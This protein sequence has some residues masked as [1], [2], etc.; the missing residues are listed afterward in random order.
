M[1][2][3]SLMADKY[4]IEFATGRYQRVTIPQIRKLLKD[5]DKLELGVYKSGGDP[6]HSYMTAIMQITISSVNE[7]DRVNKAYYEF[8]HDSKKPH[9]AIWKEQ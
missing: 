2:G 9:Y 5:T 3:G 8:S 7:M 1:D 6:N 4:G